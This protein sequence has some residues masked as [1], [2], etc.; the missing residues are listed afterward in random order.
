MGGAGA[1]GDAAPARGVLPADL[2]RPAGVRAVGPRG[3]SPDADAGGTGGRHRSG[4][5]RGRLAAGIAVRGVRG[6]RAGRAVRVDVS[7]ADRA[8]RP[9]RRDIPDG[10]GCGA[11]VGTDGAGRD[12]R[13]LGA[14]AHQLGNS[15]RG[16][17]D[18][19]SHRAVHGRGPGLPRLVR[20]AAAPVA[21]P[22][23]RGEVHDDGRG[24]RHGR[25]LPGGPGACSG[26]APRRGHHGPV[27][28][29]PPR[30]VADPG[31]RAGRVARQRPPSLRRRRRRGGRGHP[32]VPGRPGRARPRRPAAHHAAGHRRPGHRIRGAG[33]A[34][35]PP[36]G[37]SRN[38]RPRRRGAGQVRHGDSGHPL[39]PGHR[40]RRGTARHR[41]SRRR[42]HGRVRGHPR[43]RRRARFARAAR[44]G[45]TRR[46][47]AGRRLRNRPRP[48]ARIRDPVRRRTPGPAPRPAR[49]VPG[50]DRRPSV[51]DPGRPGAGPPRPAADRAT[52]SAPTGNTGPSPSRAGS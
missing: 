50:P 30:R 19:P 8:D 26:P 15:C 9:V 13:G 17:R 44:P 29:R 52:C 46:T 37:R 49:A 31:C 2:L 39:R 22:G 7:P 3:P 47:R 16:G 11:S 40:R 10:Q 51:S 24:V 36:P 38:P 35:R 32:P 5:R 14:G 27:Q 4:A 25:G 12:R 1:G 45:R 21:E 6:M 33:A 34:P 41:P 28:Q 20:P 18:G 42:A 48:G 43:R 23:R